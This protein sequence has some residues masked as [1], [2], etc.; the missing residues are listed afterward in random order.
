MDAR[1]LKEGDHLLTE[2]G[3]AVIA[4][5]YSEPERLRVY[6]LEVAPHH[7]Y[8]VSARGVLVHNRAMR[9]P[10]TIVASAGKNFRDHFLRKK[11][12]MQR[13]LGK[14]YGK[15][16]NGAGEEF[17]ADISA[18]IADETFLY[19]G[20][21]TINRGSGVHLVYRGAGL[22]VLTKPNGEWV[23]IFEAGAGRDLG[24]QFL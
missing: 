13:L 17:L 21:A 14:T 22:T 4:K 18:G 20:K 19:A 15:L 9:N 7:T 24:L 16:K 2:H 6:N 11:V 23:T 8:T 5:V 1:D 12:F 10:Q 3:P